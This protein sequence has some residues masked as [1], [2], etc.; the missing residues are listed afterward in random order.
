MTHYQTYNKQAEKFDQNGNVA[1]QQ[2]LISLS[3]NVPEVFAENVI[4]YADTLQEQVEA[5]TISEAQRGNLLLQ[6]QKLW[7]AASAITDSV[8]QGQIRQILAEAEY[9]STVGKMDTVEKLKDLGQTNLAS[10]VMS[11]DTGAENLI[12]AFDSLATKMSDSLDK[13]GDALTDAVDGLSLE[14]AIKVAKK[15]GLNLA[16]DFQM[17]GDKFYIN[18]GTAQ[19]RINSSQVES[20]QLTLSAL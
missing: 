20:T 8:L 5:G 19:E 4:K 9:D 12:T 18:D 17:V 16:T 14:D 7:E 3:Q 1:V 10:M 6:Q 15:A 13:M 11:I 2:A